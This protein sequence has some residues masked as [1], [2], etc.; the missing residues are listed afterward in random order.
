MEI[1][2]DLGNGRFIAR[3]G[4]GKKITLHAIN[5]D[6]IANHHK[7]SIR[8]V[9]KKVDADIIKSIEMQTYGYINEIID[10]DDWYDIATNLTKILVELYKSIGSP[11]IFHY[12]I[13]YINPDIYGN[14][15]TFR[16]YCKDLNDICNE[17]LN[18]KTVST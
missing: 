16:K 1:I 15:Q 2:K 17:I 13:K 12:S 14:A 7:D 9:A 18:E 8:E 10:I 5:K 3:D 6:K 4:E 11:N